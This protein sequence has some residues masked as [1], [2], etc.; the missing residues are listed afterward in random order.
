MR[1]DP[2]AE[3]ELIDSV[4][5]SH[6]RQAKARASGMANFILRRVHAERVR[7]ELLPLR[8]LVYEYAPGRMDVGSACMREVS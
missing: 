2:G 6:T 3:H 7:A 5:R 4:Q 1:T 8:T